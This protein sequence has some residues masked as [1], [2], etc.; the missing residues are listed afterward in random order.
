MIN[1]FVYFKELHHGNFINLMLPL[2]ELGF[3]SINA[4]VKIE[5]FRS[6]KQLILNF[7]MDI[8]MYT[9]FYYL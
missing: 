2:V 8:S 3:K 7:A 5:A 9:I 4:E 6:W 1:V